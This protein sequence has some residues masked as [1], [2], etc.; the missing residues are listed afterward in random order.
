[1]WLLPLE[2][3]ELKLKC[4]KYKLIQP[5]SRNKSFRTIGLVADYEKHQVKT[6]MGITKLSH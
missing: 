4:V 1:M 2:R 3:Y 6:N 5:G